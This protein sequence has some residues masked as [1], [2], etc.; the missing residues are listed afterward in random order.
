MIT[1]LFSKLIWVLHM[2]IVSEQEVSEHFV[3]QCVFTYGAHVELLLDIPTTAS[4]THL[5]RWHCSDECILTHLTHRP[6][7]KKLQ[8]PPIWRVQR[9]PGRHGLKELLH[10]AGIRLKPANGRNRSA[11]DNCLHRTRENVSVNGW[12]V[13]PRW[14]E[15]T[16]A[17]T[18][19]S[20]HPKYLVRSW[21]WK[22][23]STQLQSNSHMVRRKLY[24]V[25]ESLL[26]LT[27]DAAKDSGIS[28]WS[29][30]LQN[31]PSAYST[32]QWEVGNHKS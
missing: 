21:W 5:W 29:H 19:T 13:S 31:C 23:R 25:P 3:H 6:W 30:D 11:I 32:R 7:R 14:S 16:I 10:K 20:R 28:H 15:K 2:E 8:Y 18:A 24:C 27:C 26:H 9:R 17:Q 4:R 12:I 22:I 1:D